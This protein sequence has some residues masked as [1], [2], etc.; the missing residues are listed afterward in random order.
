MDG[1][2]DS[3]YVH[4][5]T[6]NTSREQ[7]PTELVMA[8]GNVGPLDANIQVDPEVY[9]TRDDLTFNGIPDVYTFRFDGF[10][11]GDYIKLRL[12]A[13]AD[14]AGASFGGLL[15]DGNRVL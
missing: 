10:A 14:G 4:V 1:V 3:F 13:H 11:P 9:P 6:D 15:F 2:P 8:R 12:S 5:V 7:D